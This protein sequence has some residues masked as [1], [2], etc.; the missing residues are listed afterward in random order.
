MKTGGFGS[1]QLKVMLEF[2]R[3]N[4]KLQPIVITATGAEEKARRHG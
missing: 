4:P 3:R 1:Q 2:C